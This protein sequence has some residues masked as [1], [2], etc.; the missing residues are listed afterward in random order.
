MPLEN[1]EGHSPVILTLPYTGTNMPRAIAQRL[2]DDA[3][4]ITAPDRYLD[5]LMGGLHSDLNVL[6]ANFHRFLSDVDCLN[7]K[8]DAR[9]SNGMIGVVPL[10]D[11]SGA[12]IW[13]HPP[14]GADAAGWR[15]MCYAP[16]HAALGAQIARIRA[17]YGYAVVVNCRARP[18]HIAREF[19][20]QPVD[21]SLAT[22]MG[23]SCAVGLGTTLISLLNSGQSISAKLNGRANTGWTTR[24]Y[25]KPTTGVHALDL[26]INEDCYL[27]GG[28][29][30]GEYDHE[31]AEQ[32]RVLLREMLAYT[33]TWRP[34]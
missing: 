34:N 30:A 14:T 6:R 27:T 21:V 12:P 19:N 24:H 10:L 32:V 33:I 2:Q 26:E 23:A 20:A 11:Q 15:A 1:V 25:G 4:V 9:P 5:R 8:R 29:D 3:Q 16:Y 13:H 22:Y 28:T 17:R 31:R 7:P 18:A